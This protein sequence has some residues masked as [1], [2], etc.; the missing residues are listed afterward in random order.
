MINDIVADSIDTRVKQLAALIR[1]LQLA[2]VQ[3]R[4][5]RDVF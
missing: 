3:I 5:F 2:R 1:L 4:D